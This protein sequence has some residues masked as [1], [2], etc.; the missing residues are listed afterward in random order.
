VYLLRW[1]IRDNNGNAIGGKGAVR[2]RLATVTKINPKTVRIKYPNWMGEE[3]GDNISNTTNRLIVLM[4]NGG[5]LSDEIITHTVEME[6]KL[7]VKYQNKEI[8][9]LKKPIKIKKLK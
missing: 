1:T 2:H 8:K 9:E 3:T 6:K 4:K 7:A 5:I